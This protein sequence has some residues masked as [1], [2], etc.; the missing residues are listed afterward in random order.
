MDGLLENGPRNLPVVGERADEYRTGVYAAMM[1][2]TLI[3]VG[4]F[5]SLLMIEYLPPLAPPG[6]FAIGS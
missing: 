1:L 6:N 5:V 2:M 3:G 4:S